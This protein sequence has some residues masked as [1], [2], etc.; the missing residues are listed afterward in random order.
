MYVKNKRGLCIEL[1]ILIF[2]YVYTSIMKTLGNYVVQKQGKYI[3]YG[4]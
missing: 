1:L 2:R 3:R 4:I